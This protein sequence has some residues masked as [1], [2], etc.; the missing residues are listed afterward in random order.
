MQTTLEKLYEISGFLFCAKV[1]FRDDDDRHIR[2]QVVHASDLLDKLIRDLQ[3]K[4][5]TTML[6]ERRFQMQQ[7]ARREALRQERG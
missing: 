3:E 1:Q 6:A 4:K 5:V 7:E 2:E